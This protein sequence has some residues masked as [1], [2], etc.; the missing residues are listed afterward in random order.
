M[1]FALLN[2]FYSLCV[3]HP[4]Q[5]SKRRRSMSRVVQ[6]PRFSSPFPLLY[7]QALAMSTWI[8]D[9]MCPSVIIWLRSLFGATANKNNWPMLSACGS[10]RTAKA[11]LRLYPSILSSCPLFLRAATSDFA[12][13]WQTLES[14]AILW[15]WNTTGKP[16]GKIHFWENRG[17]AVVVLLLLHN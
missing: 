1:A 11:S 13:L 15:H 5:R 4:W 7:L 2:V 10:I 6:C 12:K 17:L 3:A 14:S 9:A 8:F 16:R